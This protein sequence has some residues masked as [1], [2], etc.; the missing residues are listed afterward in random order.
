M[1]VVSQCTQHCFK[2]V[3]SIRRGKLPKGLKFGF[4]YRNCVLFPNYSQKINALTSN[5]NF[6]RPNLDI[7]LLQFCKYVR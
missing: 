5:V 3:W 4:W 6:L 2:L 1:S 7:A